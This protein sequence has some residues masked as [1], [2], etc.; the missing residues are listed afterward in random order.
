MSLPNLLTEHP[1]NVG[2]TYIQHFIAAVFI[3]GRLL[4]ASLAC[5]CHA[6]L[7][8]AFT[9]TGS[10]HIRALYGELEKRHSQ[11]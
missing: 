2:E 5:L 7:P 4:M 6:L 11:S 3:S 8:F 10:K 9:H 1:N